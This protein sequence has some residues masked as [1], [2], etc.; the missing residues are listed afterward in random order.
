ML[1]EL[2]RI[3]MGLRGGQRMRMKP[4]QLEQLRVTT[5]DL[6]AELEATPRRP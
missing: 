4:S 6:V 3:E 1:N 5:L 2:G